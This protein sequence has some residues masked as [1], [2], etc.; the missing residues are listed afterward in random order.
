M[1]V[2]VSVRLRVRLLLLLLLLLLMVLRMLVVNLRRTD[3]GLSVASNTRP[4]AM[5]GSFRDM[6]RSFSKA[7]K[8]VVDIPR[9]CVALTSSTQS[10]AKCDRFF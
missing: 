2:G 4:D 6:C 10:A 8:D 7:C 5:M 1:G 3:T 9:R